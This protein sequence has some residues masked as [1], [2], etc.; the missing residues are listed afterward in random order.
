[1]WMLNFSKTTGDNLATKLENLTMKVD[2]IEVTLGN[3]ALGLLKEVF[4]I[5]KYSTQDEH[6]AWNPI[7]SLGVMF[8]AL[9]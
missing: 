5:K 2:N 3:V 1:M 6:D 8:M 9:I 7:E 4:G